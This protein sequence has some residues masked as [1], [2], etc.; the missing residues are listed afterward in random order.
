MATGVMAGLSCLVVVITGGFITAAA[1]KEGM[2]HA[3]VLLCRLFESEPLRFSSVSC[4]ALLLS[5]RFSSD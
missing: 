4:E 1:V 2:N 3:P 5:F